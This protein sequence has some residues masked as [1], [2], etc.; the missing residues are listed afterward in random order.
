MKFKV[1]IYDYHNIFN[2][3]TLQKGMEKNKFQQKL[4]KHIVNLRRE[5]GLSQVAFGYLI[6]MEKQN[7]NR[8]ENGKTNPTAYTLQKIADALEIPLSKIF[9]FD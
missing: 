9:D 2:A 7:V 4:G 6:E 3:S 1:I 5:K 8:L